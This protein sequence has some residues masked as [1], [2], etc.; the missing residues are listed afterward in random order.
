MFIIWTWWITQP[1]KQEEK[2]ESQLSP[3]ELVERKDLV[4]GEL[5]HSSSSSLPTRQ[6]DDFVPP[7]PRRKNKEYRDSNFV[8]HV[9]R[10]LWRRKYQ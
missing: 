10:D 9:R 5:P 7:G 3:K 4:E 6:S 1:I 8:W 2:V